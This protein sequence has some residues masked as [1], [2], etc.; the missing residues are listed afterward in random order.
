MAMLCQQVLSG[1]K[2][3]GG[4]VAVT[5]MAQG[6]RW[7]MWPPPV[8]SVLPKSHLSNTSGDVDQ[9]CMV[10]V[11][12]LIFNCLSVNIL[13]GN[14]ISF[15]GGAGRNTPG[16]HNIFKQSEN[17]KVNIWVTQSK[18]E[19]AQRDIQQMLIL[20]PSYTWSV[21]TAL[22]LIHYALWVEEVW[23]TFRQSLIA[24]TT[25]LVPIETVWNSD[26]SCDMHAYHKSLLF[27][28]KFVLNNFRTNNTVP[29]YCQ[30][31]V[32]IFTHLISV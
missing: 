9:D 31:C 15:G 2:I 14:R 1:L 24:S 21:A 26:P 8:Q 29:H 18:Y 28:V 27:R 11:M 16:Q 23:K 12:K 30:Y 32:Y 22:E 19:Q 10:Q 7:G 5:L 13:K 25:N 4:I 6:D 20:N 17:A 3:G